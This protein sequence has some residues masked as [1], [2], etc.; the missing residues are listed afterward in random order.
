MIGSM[1]SD[2][3]SLDLSPIVSMSYFEAISLNSKMFD[4]KISKSSFL[5]TSSYDQSYETD[6]LCEMATN[7][8]WNGYISLDSMSFGGSVAMLDSDYLPD[9]DQSEINRKIILSAFQDKNNILD[10]NDHAIFHGEM[11]SDDVGFVHFS[12]HRDNDETKSSSFRGDSLR[13]ILRGL[14]F[15]TSSGTEFK[16]F[17]DMPLNSR[18]AHFLAVKDVAETGK[19][20][21]DSRKLLDANGLQNFFYDEDFIQY[22]IGISKMTN[23]VSEGKLRLLTLQ[24]SNELSEI[25]K[26][27]LKKEMGV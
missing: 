14:V 15:K 13:G 23:L 21:L 2:A 1:T 19:V 27:F 3:G 17:N 7:E 16:I 12:L 24:E 20:S 8:V 18:K 11:I 9:E 5:P 25:T 4:M 22:I 26:E 6:S 10:L